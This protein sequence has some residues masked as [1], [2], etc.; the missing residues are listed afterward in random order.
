MNLADQ[1]KIILRKLKV[2]NVELAEKMNQSPQNFGK[3][4]R[5]GTLNFDEFCKA[6]ELLGV[7]FE[8]SFTFPGSENI[9]LAKENEVQKEKI[10]ILEAQIEFEKKKN[11]FLEKRNRDI[12]TNMNSI[13]A[14]CDVAFLNFSDAMKVEKCVRIIRAA[15]NQINMVLNASED[16]T[17]PL[18]EKP[19]FMRKE[20]ENSKLIGKKILLVE[21]NDM[22]REITKELL[23]DM[24]ITV[25][26]AKDGFMALTKAK[27]YRPTYYDAILMDLQM[28]IMD[29]YEATIEIRKLPGMQ[30]IPIIP[31]SANNGE[32]DREKAKAAKMNDY[33]VKPIDAYKLAETLE[34]YIR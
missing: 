21:D 13:M 4:L 7:Q 16:N 2:T 8:Y 22:N 3:K 17:A 12:R 32:E 5:N 9:G 24:G 1:L 28:P 33:I 10:E 26:E 19:I 15:G 25:D 11:A 18:M 27:S 29:G 6:L 31:L 23:S 14:S 30:S 34:L 20:F